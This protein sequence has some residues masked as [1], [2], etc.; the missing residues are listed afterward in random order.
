MKGKVR[1]GRRSC[2]T[3]LGEGIAGA[4]AFFIAVGTPSRRG[5]GHADLTF[6]YEV[7]RE[8]GEKLSGEAVVVTKSTVPVGD[9]TFLSD[10]FSIAYSGASVAAGGSLCVGMATSG[11]RALG[12]LRRLG[13]ITALGCRPLGA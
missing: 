11:T 10:R 7:A 4:D 2:N 13:L 5:D 3:G 9:A 1:P 6:V 8:V 12:N